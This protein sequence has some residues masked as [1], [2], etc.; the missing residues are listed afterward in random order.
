MSGISSKAANMLDNKYEYNGKEKQEK[1]FS[2]GS[3]LEMYDYGARFYDA[4]IGRWQV[5]DPFV[6]KYISISPYAYAA[7]NPINNIDYGGL[8]PIPVR[9]LFY[10][11]AG[12]VGDNSAFKFAAQNVNRDYGGAGQ[13]NFASS[14][15]AV[16]DKVNSQADNSVQSVDFFTHGSQYALYMVRNEKTGASGENTTIPEGDRESNNLY[17]SGTAQAFQSWGGGDDQNDIGAIDYNKFT[18]DAKIEIHGCK[19]ASGTVMIDNMAEN[20]STNLFDAGKTNAVVIAHTEKANPNINGG[21]TTLKQQDYRHGPRSVYHNGKVLFSTNV[22]GNIS[23]KVI[24][25]YLKK[26]EEAGDDYDG[27]TEVYKRN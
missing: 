15:Q 10:G 13:L 6:E 19:G 26:K 27:S 11:G 3:G 18:N 25:Q 2:D 24:N 4:Q 8:A 17:A 9:L 1:E 23:Q 7:N 21:K 20:L 5:V 12:S 14:A 16:I 22:R